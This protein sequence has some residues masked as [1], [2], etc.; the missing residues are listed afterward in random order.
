MKKSKTGARCAG[1]HLSSQRL[2]RQRY[3]ILVKA[4]R[5]ANNTSDFIPDKGEGRHLKRN[6]LRSREEQATQRSKTA[7]LSPR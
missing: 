4:A 3:R 6:H 5:G 7:D 1:T 2:W